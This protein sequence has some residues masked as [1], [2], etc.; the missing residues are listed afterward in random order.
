MSII[1]EYLE[2][3]KNYL[4]EVPFRLSTKVQIDNRGDVV[5]YFK[6]EVI[7]IDDSELYIKKYFITI[8]DFKKIAYAYHYQD[9]NKKMIFRI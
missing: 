5:L 4:N 6:G 2:N 8:P 9:K 7:F 1:T 3:I